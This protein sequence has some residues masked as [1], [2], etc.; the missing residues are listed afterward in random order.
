[1]A[2]LVMAAAPDL[3]RL[4]LSLGGGAASAP[5]P[6]ETTAPAPVGA[7]AWVSDPLRSPL[8]TLAGRP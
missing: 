2:L 7:P 4:E 3:G 6:S 1:M 5:A 8:E